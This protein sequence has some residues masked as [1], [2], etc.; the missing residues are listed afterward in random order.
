[1]FFSFKISI[2]VVLIEKKNTGKGSHAMV[3]EPETIQYSL[4]DDLYSEG[5]PVLICSAVLKRTEEKGSLVLLEIRNVSEQTIQDLKLE[6]VLVPDGMNR[7]ERIRETITPEESIL[8]EIPVSEETESFSIKRMGIVFKDRTFWVGRGSSFEPLLPREPVPEENKDIRRFQEKTTELSRYVPQESGRFWRCGCGELNR[9][10]TCRRCGL[11]KAVLMEAYADSDQMIQC[12]HCQSLIVKGTKFCPYCGEEILEWKYH[13]E[14]RE[15]DE[16]GFQDRLRD[17][18]AAVQEHAPIQLR[19]PWWFWLVLITALIIGLATI[20]SI[21]KTGSN[22]GKSADA[23]VSDVVE[24]P[25]DQIKK[26]ATSQAEVEFGTG[27]Y[28]IVADKDKKIFYVN[29]WPDK[30]YADLN[31]A[32]T[33]E[34]EGSMQWTLWRDTV[35]SNC[36]TLREFM[37]EKGYDDWGCSWSIRSNRNHGT[38]FLTV[39]DGTVLYDDLEHK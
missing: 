15:R 12:P 13:T 8:R 23:V 4:P 20:L 3:Y 1:M 18:I 33:N 34:K 32:K 7:E 14:E 24:T 9:T 26:K 11:D 19:R 35:Q 10:E 16:K 38:V 27:E 21:G 5:S 25:M 31:R 6:L 22:G 39:F 30:A 29:G 37:D 28:E 2:V 17:L 36:E